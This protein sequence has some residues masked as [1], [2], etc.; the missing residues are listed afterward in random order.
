MFQISP[1]KPTAEILPVRFEWGVGNSHF[2]YPSSQKGLKRPIID[3][4]NYTFPLN[5]HIV[6]WVNL[7][8]F[9][10]SKFT[11]EII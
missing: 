7:E 4:V 10:G 3:K 9:C 5:V 8:I 11:T 1:G 2:L 6:M